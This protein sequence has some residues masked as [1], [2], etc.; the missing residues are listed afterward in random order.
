MGIAKQKTPGTCQK[1]VSTFGLLHLV[2]LETRQQGE[3]P[4]EI[5][6]WRAD[7]QGARDLQCG[8]T[9]LRIHHKSA[10]ELHGGVLY[11][12]ACLRQVVRCLRF[13]VVA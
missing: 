7:A 4:T 3:P 13:V 11:E 2:A 6:P 10:G 1:N 5:S 12:H 8:Q 9:K